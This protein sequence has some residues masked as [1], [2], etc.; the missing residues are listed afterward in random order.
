MYKFISI[1]ALSALVFGLSGMLRAENTGQGVMLEGRYIGSEEESPMEPVG[2][3]IAKE[4]G[5]RDNVSALENLP[6]I[7]PDLIDQIRQMDPI[8]LIRVII[9]LDYQPH[10]VISAQV[11]EKY[12][13]EVESIRQEARAIKASLARERRLDFPSDS[14]NYDSPLLE[15]DQAE[16]EALRDLSERN[17]ALSLTIQREIAARLK[18]EIESYQA[19]VKAGIEQLG[20]EVEF[21]T[22]AGNA[23]IALVPSG[24]VEA[25]AGIDKVARMVGD[26]KMEQGLDIA[27]D[28][29]RVGATGGLWDNGETGGTYDPAVMDTGTDLDHPALEDSTSRDNFFS[30]YL[31]AASADSAY[32]DSTTPDDLQGH[33]SHVLG[34]VA[35]YDATNRGMAYGADKAVTLKAGWR[36]TGGG[37]SMFWSDAM[38]L[39]DRALYN[40]N[41]LMWGP[42]WQTGLFNDD[43]EGINLSYW[44]QITTDETDFAR[45]WDAVVSSYPDF[46]F[47]TIAGNAGPANTRFSDPGCSY[48][49][50]TV[51]SVDD[52][53]TASRDDDTI[54][55][56]SSRGPTAGGRR[57]PDIAAPGSDINSCNNNWETQTDFVESSGTSMAAP[58]VLG[59]AMD[60]MDAGV[61]DELEIKALLIN[62]AQKN[63]PGI[64]FESDS[65][66]WSTAYGWG[67]M[68]AWSAYYHRADVDSYTVKER[69][70]AGDYILL[71]GQMRD[72][73][74]GAEGRDRATMVWNRHATY[75]PHAYPSTYYAL[76]NLNLR[77]YREADNYFIDYDTDADDNVHQVRIN[78]GASL[79]DVVVKAYAW[80]TNFAHGGTT[81]TFALAT[82]EGFVE[83]DL[84]ADFQAWGGY[85]TEMEPNEEREFEWWMDNES[86]L[87]SHSNQFD[88]VLPTGWTRVSGADPHIAGSVVSGGTS[89]NATWIL[90]A[91]ATPQDGVH[92]NVDHTHNSYAEA[93]GPHRWY[94]PV[95]VRWDTTPPLPNPMTW[96]TEPYA[97][98]TSQIRMVATTATDLHLPVQ[99]YFLCVT[100]NGNSSGWQTSS[101][102]TDSGLPPNTWCGYRVRARDSATSP[103]YTAYSAG[104]RYAYTLANLPG[105]DGFSDITQTSIRANWTANGNPAGTQYYCQNT[106]AGTNSGWTT[107][108]SW[109]SMGLSAGTTYA[110][111]VKARN[112]DGVETGWRSLGS[113]TTLPGGSPC[114]G[115]FDHDGD[116][117]GSDLAVFAADFG[118]TD[119]AG[120]PPCEGDF[121]IDGDVDGSDL[122]IFAAD[123]GRTDCP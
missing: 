74:S 92:V 63:E 21:G 98:S 31:V 73:G 57:K 113:A 119:C 58:M 46:V 85:P 103:N 110:F 114:E 84:P 30:W 22:I 62:T 122:A 60:L 105:A 18:I 68:N 16:K 41:Q 12:A 97:I 78:S 2:Q 108:T 36:N 89:S 53:N 7:E 56:Y 26:R 121:N 33:G 28:A 20:G 10:G 117:D 24:S 90:R 115:D 34:I 38:W 61:T 96:S 79:T 6:V 107:N 69:D 94:M 86:T 67:Y 109:N 64:D 91:Q 15:M 55:S 13:S 87:A 123:F 71:S 29:T 83:V 44:G 111:R 118:R 25:I 99:Y 93:W 9:F 101:T 3:E 76:S 88:L 104:S 116:V 120:G 47:T 45:F 5:G 112:G 39:V 37:G 4:G 80:D 27:D 35:S 17:E 1:L 52:Q 48:N 43:V 75:N 72:E 66:G 82:E 32:N 49:A 54:A 50:I 106:T 81:E 70:T 19:G 95:N 11:R 65:D 40:T 14:E 59:V 23:V 51:A 102:Y 100:V 42:A 77:L 8:E